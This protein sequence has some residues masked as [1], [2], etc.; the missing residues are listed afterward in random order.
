MSKPFSKKSVEFAIQRLIS[1]LD[2]DLWKSIENPE[3]PDDELGWD[4][5]TE[6]F[7]DAYVEDQQQE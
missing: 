3:D 7:I 5:L 2:Y 6:M 4:D 1:E